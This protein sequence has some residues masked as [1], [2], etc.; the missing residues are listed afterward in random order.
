MNIIDVLFEQPSISKVVFRLDR[1]FLRTPH[2]PKQLMEFLVNILP[3][4]FSILGI[5]HA[6]I[7]ALVIINS[8]QWFAP[9][10]N[11]PPF[12][13]P[14]YLTVTGMLAMA[15]GLFMLMTYSD[16][17]QKT[18]RGWQSLFIINTISILQ[19]FFSLAYSPQTFMSAVVYLFVTLYLTFEFRPYL[20][21][22]SS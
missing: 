13:H 6:L 18:L 12:I 10:S 7:G 21:H 2:L 11:T 19:S 20:K 4:L 8:A 22:P 16:I 5:L 15:N 14:F 1:F 3:S 9:L 17:K